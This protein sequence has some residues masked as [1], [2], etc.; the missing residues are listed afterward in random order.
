MKL[1]DVNV[2]LSAVNEASDD[3]ALARDWLEQACNASEGIGF[4]WVA[5]LGFLRLTTRRAIL[6]SPLPVEDALGVI[7]AWTTLPRAS[8]LNPTERHTLVLSRL[9]IAAGTAGNLTTDAHLAALAIEH[10]A[11]MVS[12]DSDFERFSGL[13]FEL[14]GGQ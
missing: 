5:L 12:F 9:L 6:P 10:G 14:L 11:T 2:L 1:P 3:H 8:I 13:D 7:R 4:A